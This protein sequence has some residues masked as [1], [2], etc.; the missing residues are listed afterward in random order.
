MRKWRTPAETLPTGNWRRIYIYIYVLYFYVIVTKHHSG[1]WIFIFMID[2]LNARIDS[3]YIAIDFSLFLSKYNKMF[4]KRTCYWLLD[5]QWYYRL[6]RHCYCDI[7]QCNKHFYFT[8]WH[9]GFSFTWTSQYF[10]G[11]DDCMVVGFITTYAISA[12]HH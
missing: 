6:W 4:R 9:S 7:T 8:T 10:N 11:G 3:L 2:I 12:Y 5:A 1:S